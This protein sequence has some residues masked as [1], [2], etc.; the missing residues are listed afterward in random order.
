MD[1]KDIKRINNQVYDQFPYLRDSTP[2][3]QK[4]PDGSI[5]LKYVGS[6]VT[7]SGQTIPL[8][9][10]VKASD[11]GKILQISSSR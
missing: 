10:K 9:I 1:S 8:S 2:K 6:S 5:I 11:N 3:I 4:S 7:A